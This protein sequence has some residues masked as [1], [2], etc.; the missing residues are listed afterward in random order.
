MKTLLLLIPLFFISLS[1]KDKITKGVFPVDSCNVTRMSS[2]KLQG[3]RIHPVGPRKLLPPGLNITADIG[4]PVMASFSGAV[5]LADWHGGYGKSII[6]QSDSIKTIYGHLDSIYLTKG[7]IIS[8]GTVIG[9]L[10]NTGLS[11]GP[12]LFFGIKKEGKF[13][14]P[15]LYLD[16]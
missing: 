8:K 3:I 16:F 6:I 2:N 14:D 1:S 13:V 7:D 9:E 12:H 5:I 10:G 15:K 11:T 4:T